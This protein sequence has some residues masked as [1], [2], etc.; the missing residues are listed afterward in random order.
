MIFVLLE[1]SYPEERLKWYRGVMQ[2]AEYRNDV[3]T[4]LEKENTYHQTKERYHCQHID[5]SLCL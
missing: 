5:R 4:E 2:K 3:Y 1:T